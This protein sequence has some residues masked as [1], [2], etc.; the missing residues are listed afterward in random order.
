M[1]RVVSRSTDT[2]PPMTGVTSA[3]VPVTLRGPR[4]SDASA[5]R[6]VRLANQHLIEPFW[7]HSELSWAERHSCRAW[8]REWASAHRRMRCGAA[9]HTVIEVEG[10]LAGQ[11][12]AWIDGYHGRGE[13]GL[14]VDGRLATRGVGTTAIRLMVWHLFEDR[15]VERVAAPIAAG[16]AVTIRMAQRLGFVREGVL[17]SYMTVGSGRCDHELWSLTRADWANVCALYR[18]SG[19]PHG[20]R[21][22]RV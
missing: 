9:V 2:A 14:W 19:S 5:W 20:E 11:C 13:L 3:G 6:S 4:L 22:D 15:G 7:D 21:R 8:I 12:D 10:R 17:R 18:D 1:I 16:N